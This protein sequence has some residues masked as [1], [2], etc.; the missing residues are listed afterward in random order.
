MALT[1][2]Q[3]NILRMIARNRVESGES[4]IARGVAL[5][6]LLDAPRLSQDID[7]FHDTQEAVRWAVDADS[8]ALRA[9][10]CE[11]RIEI[12]R[13]AF[14]EAIISK[15]TENYCRI[16]WVEDSAYRFFPLVEHPDFGLVL[17]PF[18]LATNKVLALVG[19]AVP[20]YWVDIFECDARLQPLGY[21]VWAASGKDLGLNPSF[22]LDQARRSARYTEIELA[23]VF[24]EGP[25][26][27]AAML[28]IE[29]RRI[30][31]LAE[32]VVAALPWQR[33]GECVLD[34]DGK[35]LRLDS[36]SLVGAL[37][38][39]EVRFHAGSIFGAFPSL[40]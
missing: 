3:L 37:E 25:R 38:R 19:R 22:I 35:I 28:S 17:H 6:A 27:S 36:V 1:D 7:I 33:V 20:R 21:L 18:D 15:G 4:Y 32:E 31:A 9:N 29:W 40:A 23:E 11:V 2:F 34:R 30:M 24:F 10:G 16:Q 13:N 14:V 39:G 26:P 8:N 5:N 12:D